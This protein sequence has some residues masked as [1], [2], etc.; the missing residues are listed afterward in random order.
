MLYKVLDFVFFYK[1]ASALLIQTPE[2]IRGC[3]GSG[4]PVAV[5][6]SRPD[7]FSSL[8]PCSTQK[9]RIDIE[10]RI[11][12]SQIFRMILVSTCF[13]SGSFNFEQFVFIANHLMDGAFESSSLPPYLLRGSCYGI[14]KWVSSLISPQILSRSTL[15]K[16]HLGWLIPLAKW[17]IIPQL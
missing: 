1:A 3:H 2:I 5:K 9:L 8:G 13:F 12:T 6:D 7:I 14:L 17:V 4:N 15:Q 11:L 16:S 10:E